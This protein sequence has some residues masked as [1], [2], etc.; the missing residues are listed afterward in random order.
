MQETDAIKDYAAQKEKT[1]RVFIGIAGFALP[2]VLYASLFIT[3]QFTGVLP[4]ISHYFF[5]RANPLFCLILGYVAITLIIYK[6]YDQ[7]DD[8]VSTIAGIAAL[9]VIIIPAEN[10]YMLNKGIYKNLTVT[11]IPES[12]V[13][14]IVHFVAAGIF[15]ICLSIMAAFQFTQTKKINGIPAQP[16]TN[17]KRMRNMFYRISAI[18]MIICIVLIAL[19]ANGIIFSAEYYTSHQLTFWFESLAVWAFALSWLV[20]GL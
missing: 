1:L 18:V 5:T 11:S 10:L 6:G 2:L 4:S 12:P 20:K 7:T 16:I 13:R 3:N 8:I 19:G 9:I 14:P 15:L 17:D